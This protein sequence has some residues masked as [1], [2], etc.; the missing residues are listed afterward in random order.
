MS[1]RSI[2][3]VEH[4]D[5]SKGFVDV[6]VPPNGRVRLAGSAYDA[7]VQR[8]YSIKVIALAGTWVALDFTSVVD[9]HGSEETDEVFDAKSGRS[10]RFF[11]AA[12]PEGPGF[13]GIPA[14][15]VLGRFVL[16]RFGQLVLALIQDGRC[17]IVG[18]QPSG[19]RRVLDSG[20]EALIP[21]ASLKLQGHT[22]QWVHAGS[23]RSTTL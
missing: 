12:L 20:P 4:G 9:F 11:E 1:N 13:E 6:C 8:L 16:N 2:K 21:S 22:V 5:E 15:A 18:I 19:A 23:T 7:T 3:V 14:S 10:Y 17:R